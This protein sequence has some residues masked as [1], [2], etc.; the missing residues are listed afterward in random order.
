MAENRGLKTRGT[1][2]T[3]VKLELLSELRRISEETDVP[4][5]KLIDRSIECYL[6]NRAAQK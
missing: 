3:T 5:S 6:S 4:I 1:L 2:S